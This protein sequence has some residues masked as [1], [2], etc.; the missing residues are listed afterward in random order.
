MKIHR[1]IVSELTGSLVEGDTIS[2]GDG[3][4]VH[5]LVRV[6]RMKGGD[7]II[8]CDNKGKDYLVSLKEL[9]R[10]SVSG[11]IKEVRPVAPIG[12]DVMMCVALVKGSRFDETLLHLVEVGVSSI[13]PLI[14]DRT[15]K[16]DL[17]QERALRILKEGAEQSG[18]GTV[19]YLHPIMKL[20]EAFALAQSEGR[21]IVWCDTGL[22]ETKKPSGTKLALFVGP[23]GGFTESER[24]LAKKISVLPASLGQ[25]ILRAETAAL[26][27][28]YGAVNGTL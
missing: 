15:E 5:Q 25:T 19:P 1:F 20:E 26:V 16:K 2:L 8:L 21:E 12:R 14:T 10:E 6:L 11:V 7:T 13:V 17:N 24:E 18:R 27:A 22:G 3:D 4:M 23:E 28:G 9:S